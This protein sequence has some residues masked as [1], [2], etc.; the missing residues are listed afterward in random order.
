MIEREFP[1]RFDFAEAESRIYARWKA[2]N[3][4]AS[5]YDSQGNVLDETKKDAETFV[6]V[7]PPPNI[8]G[9]LHMGHALNNTVQDALIRFKRMDGYDALW[10]PGTDHAGIATQTVV[11]KQLDAEGIDF[12]ELGREKMIERIWEWRNRY[13]DAI[14]GQLERLGCSCDW[15]RTRFTMDEGLNL[16]V[17]EA[18]VRLFEEGLIYR[19]KRI[20]NWCPVD[21]TAL[22]LSLIHI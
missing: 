2:A 4:F 13:G 10:V 22:S 21:R 7:I 8:T 5:A 17:R 20:V 3:A 9:R 14:I 16:A 11:K 12:R 18:F 15:S 6:I 19:G 1:K